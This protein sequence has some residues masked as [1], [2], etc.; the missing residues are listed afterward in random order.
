MNFNIKP[1]RKSDYFQFSCS[2]CAACCR[3]LESALPIEPPDAVH[4]AKFL[5]DEGAPI[6]TLDDFYE[7]FAELQILDGT[8]FFPY[9]FVKT[10]GKDGC[11]IFLKDSRCTVQAVKPRICRQY[12]ISITPELENNK[13][14]PYLCLEKPHHFFGGKIRV[15]NWLDVELTEEDKAFLRLENRCIGELGKLMRKL[16]E[17]CQQ[18]FLLILYYRYGRYD[19]QREFIPQYED[20]MRRLKRKLL[21]LSRD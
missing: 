10:T 12:P 19:F 21:E 17:R 8:A 7:Q 6:Q 4:I 13:L 1:V 14:V 3:H 20:N 16:G 5:K 9:Y 11:C 15:S 18:A 2:K